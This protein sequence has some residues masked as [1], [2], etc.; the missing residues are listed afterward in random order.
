MDCTFLHERYRE[1]S[2]TLEGRYMFVTKMIKEDL[3][4]GRFGV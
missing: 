4:F 1:L 3:E 2:T